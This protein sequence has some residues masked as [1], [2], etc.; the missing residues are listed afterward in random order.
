M[1]EATERWHE[2]AKAFGT[3]FEAIADSQWDGATPCDAWTVRQL[4]DHAVGTQLFLGSKLGM[5]P[6][7]TAWSDVSHA[8]GALLG[9]KAALVGSV[10]IPG[11]GEM[12]KAQVLDV[13]INDLLIHTWDLARAI[14][15]DERL[16]VALVTS[17]LEWLQ[18]LPLALMRSSGRYVAEIA[19]AG[20]ADVQTRMLAFAGRA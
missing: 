10:E 7:E 6:T 15:A 9:D 2:S 13:C 11:V 17:C 14:G 4:V 1:S 8:M 3:R 19:V 20:D 5:P 16:P 18:Q 12:T